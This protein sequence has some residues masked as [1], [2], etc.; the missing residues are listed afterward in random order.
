MPFAEASKAALTTILGDAVALNQGYGGGILRLESLATGVVW[1]GAI[2]QVRR[3]HPAPYVARLCG[4]AYS[5]P[6]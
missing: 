4:V 6:D 1:D 2:G 3:W 5:A